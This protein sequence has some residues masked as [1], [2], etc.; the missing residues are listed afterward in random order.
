MRPCLVVVVLL[1]TEFG[2]AQKAWEKKPF[3][4]WS[5]KDVNQLMSDSPWAKTITLGTTNISLIGP[6]SGSRNRSQGGA[7]GMS[8]DVSHESNPRISYQVQLRSATPIRQAVARKLQIDNNYEAMPAERRAVVDA[9]IGDYLQQKFDDVI[10]I[11]VAFTSNVP[12]YVSDMRRYW[13]GQ[14]SELLK[15]SMYLNA[16]GKRLEP[17]G[18]VSGEGLFQVT[19]PRPSD[20]TAGSNLALEFDNPRFGVLSEQKVFVQF[21]PKN[22]AF[23]GKLTF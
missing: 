7:L 13:M 1:L 12:T 22:M 23:N 20:F 9:K 4:K 15:G 19:F 8:D 18:Y 3:E 21:R 5:A 2:F 10:V 11:Q 17:E 6:G 16:A 14:T